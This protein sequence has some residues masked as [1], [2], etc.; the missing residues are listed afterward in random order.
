MKNIQRSDRKSHMSWKSSALVVFIRSY[1]LSRSGRIT[2]FPP[3]CARMRT[4]ECCQSMSSKGNSAA[5]IPRIPYG[6]SAFTDHDRRC[7]EFALSCGVDAISQSFVESGADIEAVRAAAAAVGKTPFLIAKIERYESIERFDKILAAADGIMVARGDLGVEVPIEEMAVLQMRRRLFK[8]FLARPAAAG[9]L[10]PA[11]AGS[12]DEL[13]A[14]TPFFSAKMLSRP[15]PPERWRTQWRS[16][17]TSHGGGS[18]RSGTTGS[19]R[20]H[21]RTSVAV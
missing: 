7:L 1:P 21:K 2:S 17:T 14:R 20:G 3:F 4:R 18:E 12:S 10:L 11:S 8:S 5:E 9:S 15:Q 19:G 6:I 16:A 13:M